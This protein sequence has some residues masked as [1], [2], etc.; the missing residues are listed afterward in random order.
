MFLARALRAFS[1]RTCGAAWS[2]LRSMAF[3]AHARKDD[4]LTENAC[5]GFGHPCYRFRYLTELQNDPHSPSPSAGAERFTIG[6]LR[7]TAFRRG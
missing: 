3:N 2:F 7:L 4:D 1:R 6:S 5:L